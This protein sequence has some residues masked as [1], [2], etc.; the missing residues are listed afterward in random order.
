MIEKKKRYMNSKCDLWN[1]N[2]GERKPCSQG[3]MEGDRSTKGN[4]LGTDYEV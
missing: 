1:V 2:R 4:R 3:I